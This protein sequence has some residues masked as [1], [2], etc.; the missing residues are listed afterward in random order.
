MLHP[1]LRIPSEVLG[2]IICQSVLLRYNV[3]QERQSILTPSHV[4]SLW[5]SVSLSTPAMWTFISFQSSKD[6]FISREMECAR[7]WLLRSGARPLS[8]VISLVSIEAFRLIFKLLLPESTRW[9]E[10]AFPALGDFNV[11]SQATGGLPLL[12]S[13]EFGSIESSSSLISLAIAPHLRRL[14][15]TISLSLQSPVSSFP[16]GQ[17]TYLD[18]T[19]HLT[20][21]FHDIL[22]LATSVSFL[23][24]KLR[25]KLPSAE[26]FKPI[27]NSSISTMHLFNTL[28]Y[29]MDDSTTI[30]LD[31]LALSFLHHLRLSAPW[32][33]VIPF[34]SRSACSLSSLHIPMFPEATF[35]ELMELLPTLRDLTIVL[36]AVPDW[37]TVTGVLTLTGLTGSVS[38]RVPNLRSLNLRFFIMNYQPLNMDSFARMIASRW[39]IMHDISRPPLKHVNVIVNGSVPIP[40]ST[41]NRLQNFVEE[42]LDVVI[43]NGIAER[44]LFPSNSQRTYHDVFYAREEY[45]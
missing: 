30:F 20:P 9:R 29:T 34:I 8:I 27:T 22:Y 35:T 18:I 36:R 31:R 13:V 39:G 33:G 19:T 23:Q 38:H 37:D 3:V 44:Q 14:T 2:E 41:Y 15:L 12:E 25:N 6:K 16:W 21:A 42:G 32:A 5:R 43:H 26:Q 17:L 1:I 45:E 24:V 4:C 7:A 11:L 28:T 40:F 10:I